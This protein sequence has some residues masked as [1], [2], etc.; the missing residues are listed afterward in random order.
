VPPWSW[1]YPTMSLPRE[2]PDLGVKIVELGIKLH[3]LPLHVGSEFRL[4]LLPLL[5]EMEVLLVRLLEQ[6]V[7]KAELTR[8][9]S[10][11]LGGTRGAFA[12]HVRVLPVAPLVAIHV[13][14]T[15]TMTAWLGARLLDKGSKVPIFLSE[16]S[17]MGGPIL[18][19]AVMR[20]GD[21]PMEHRSMSQEF[22]HPCSLFVRL[23]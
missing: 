1:R 13:P 9:D 14:L 20:L 18:R 4:K 21:L 16:L 10:R 17:Q 15:C 11:E 7:S 6:G 8:V 3:K 23:T 5:P 19:H 2:N 22:F 12:R